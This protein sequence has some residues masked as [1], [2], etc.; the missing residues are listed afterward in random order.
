MS[1][2][3]K[4]DKAHR[5]LDRVRMRLNEAAQELEIAEMAILHTDDVTLEELNSR[6][7]PFHQ[8][9]WLQI[10]PTQVAVMLSGKHHRGVSLIATVDPDPV[11]VV[12][13]Y[14][15]FRWNF[16]EDRKAE[17]KQYRKDAIDNAR[18]VFESSVVL[19]TGAVFAEAVLGAANSAEKIDN[20]R[21]W[22]WDKTTIP[23]LPA[24]IAKL[25]QTNRAPLAEG[26]PG[27]LGAAAVELADLPDAPA[28]PGDSLTKAIGQ[29]LFRNMSGSDV[30]QGLL[31]T[32]Q[33][34]AANGAKEAAA[35]AQTNL[36]LIF[37]S[38]GPYSPCK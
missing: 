15:G 32:G 21:A 19:S 14:L 8:A 37:N 2:T 9:L 1:C 29:P 12:G 20:A 3:D 16:P 34:A 11:A 7:L 31:K 38:G 35:Q 26:R 22:Q 24:A 36:K 10:D 18:P 23:I 28:G 33:D 25:Q 6:R 27:L 13:T 30:L 4:A 17:E 5:R